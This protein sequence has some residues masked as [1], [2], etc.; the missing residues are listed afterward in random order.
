MFSEQTELSAQKGKKSAGWIAM[1]GFAQ[2]RRDQAL[3]NEALEGVSSAP[4]RVPSDIMRGVQVLLR[5]WILNADP[6]SSVS[7]FSCMPN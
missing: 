4:A 7:S 3:V 5:E 6:S 1:K 2:R